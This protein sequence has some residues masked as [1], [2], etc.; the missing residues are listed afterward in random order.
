M[1]Q[2]PS[3]L[4]LPIEKPPRRIIYPFPL[5]IAIG[6]TLYLFAVEKPI[7]AEII[8][9]TDLHSKPLTI[10]PLKASKPKH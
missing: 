2:E 10:S 8:V 6:P 5:I 4:Q 9:T 1:S 3:I 7:S